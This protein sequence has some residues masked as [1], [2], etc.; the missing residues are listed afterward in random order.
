MECAQK[1]ISGGMPM[2]LLT[3]DN[4]F[5]LLTPDHKNADPYNKCKDLAAQMVEVTGFTA[6]RNGVTMLGVTDAKAAEAK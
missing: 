2:G 3:A 6:T 5:Y 1:C 4:K